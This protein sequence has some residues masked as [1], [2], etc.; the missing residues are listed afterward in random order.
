MEP[1]KHSE[2]TNYS[3]RFPGLVDLV[4]LDDS[5]H[6]LVKSAEGLKT[7]PD[8][9][10]STDKS[11]IPPKLEAVNGWWMRTFGGELYWPWFTLLGTLV[12]LAVAKLDRMIEARMVARR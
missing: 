10:D 11:Y 4:L 1:I 6:Y 8:Y 12:T 9:K 2:I 5:V 7:F 3:A